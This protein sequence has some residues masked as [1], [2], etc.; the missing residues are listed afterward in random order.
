MRIQNLY[1]LD[2]SFDGLS[3][4]K[5]PGTTLISAEISEGLITGIPSCKIKVNIPLG[6]FNDRT[7][8]DGTLIQ[9]I[10]TSDVFNFAEKLAFRLT[11]IN[12]IEINQEFVY[13]DIEGRLDF[14]YGYKNANPYNLYGTSADVF[15]N[16]AKQCG[17][18]R[19]EVDSTNDIQLWAAGQNNVYQFLNQTAQHGWIND[20]SCMLWCLDRHKILLY[21]NLTSLFRSR[22]NTVWTFIQNPYPDPNKKQYCYTEATALINAGKENLTKG[23]YGN[24][25]NYFNFADYN[26]QTRMP[27]KVVA[28][29]NFININKNLLKTVDGLSEE[30][31][32]FD[33]GNYHS[34][35]WTAKLQNERIF[36]T[37]STYVALKSQFFMAYRIGQIVTLNYIDSQN[38]K[39]KV[40]ATSGTFMIN[41][42]KISITPSAITSD[43]ILAMQG[44]NGIAVTQ[45]VY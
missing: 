14:Y 31:N 22:Q 43:I 19:C 28:E 42:I 11:V 35:Y 34:N 44:M 2:I 5:A 9:F 12:K 3:I 7:P 10:L 21:K 30:W 18:L 23:G 40:N 25:I 37:Y 17:N 24:N 1:D 27:K 16:I 32:S 8:I 29:S 39:N 6:W 15:V 36:A 4:F 38:P 26:W 33:V 41:G 45:E 13:L 20:T